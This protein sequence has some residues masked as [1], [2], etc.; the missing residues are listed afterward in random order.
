M[1]IG[2]NIYRIL[3]GKKPYPLMV[4]NKKHCENL[5]DEYQ[6]LKGKTALEEKELFSSKMILPINFKEFER[7]GYYHKKF[8]ELFLTANKDDT[9]LTFEECE[10]LMPA[11][12]ND[13][14]KNA[15][16][17]VQDKAMRDFLR[18]NG[19]TEATL[20]ITST[21]YYLMSPKMYNTTLLAINLTVTWGG[22][23]RAGRLKHSKNLIQ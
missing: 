19:S 3:N 10:Q 17:A 9:D 13:L 20:R 8:K 23:W 11:L 16:N 15:G 6:T 12:S 14:Q 22:S 4:K 5:Y 2:Y 21:R 7:G 1:A 18:E